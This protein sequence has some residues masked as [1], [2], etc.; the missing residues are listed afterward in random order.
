M[1]NM[2]T[3]LR[4]CKMCGEGKTTDEF[5]ITL[6]NKDGSVRSRRGVCKICY[7][8]NKLVKAKETSCHIDRDSVPKPIACKGCGMG[9][10]DVDFKWRD[11][12]CN[13]GWRNE[14][15]KCFN[16]KGY[17]AKSRAVR[18]ATDE[19]AY[20]KHNAQVHLDWVHRNQ[21]K[22]ETQ[23]RMMKTVPERRWKALCRYVRQKHG[24]DWEKHI[25]VQEKDELVTRLS[26][27]CHYCGHKPNGTGDDEVNGLDRVD[28]SGIYSLANTVPCC[29]VC[30]SMK[31]T[32][33]ADQFI[34]NVW[35]ITDKLSVEMTDE[36]LA[37]IMSNARPRPLGKDKQRLE[38][39][40]KD[41]TCKLTKEETIR[42]W[43]SECY[44]CGRAPALGIDRV[45][46][47]MGYELDNCKSC[48]TQCNYMKKDWNL[49]EFMGHVIRV[50]KFTRHWVINDVMDKL[51]NNQGERKPVVAFDPITSEELIIF[52]SLCIAARTINRTPQ[53]LQQFLDK[54]C[55]K[56]N[57]KWGYTSPRNYNMQNLNHE[58]AQKVILSMLL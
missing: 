38:G 32:Y 56:Y 6:R 24:G 9:V 3:T 43:A 4:V 51:T 19:E 15:N 47:S 36:D 41:K 34:W 55:V 28:S 31:L 27:A 11:D 44:L 29:G 12:I 23:S 35:N 30:N 33:S 1:I 10:P 14:C 16:R 18:R 8:K 21:D 46:A 2:A 5:E 22:V 50:N 26:D 48:C 25:N 40:K 13:G 57:V 49:D 52:P 20:L 37:T 17:S 53:H 54:N 39:C 45:N 42:L 7:K 58:Q